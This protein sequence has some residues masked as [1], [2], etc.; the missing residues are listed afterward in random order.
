[1]TNINILFPIIRTIFHGKIEVP[2]AR[3]LEDKFGTVPSSFDVINIAKLKNIELRTIKMFCR[4]I[5]CLPKNLD[6]N[7]LYLVE[8]GE[9]EYN[10]F[11]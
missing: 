8:Q 6:I 3:K 9:L 5:L 11:L 10:I 4:A 2:V 1:M 7:S